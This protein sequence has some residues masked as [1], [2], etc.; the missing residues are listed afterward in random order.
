MP[1]ARNLLLRAAL[2][3]LPLI[4]ATTS[5]VAASN[6]G[7]EMPQAS[8]V[9]LSHKVRLLNYIVFDLSYYNWGLTYNSLKQSSAYDF[10]DWSTDNCSGPNV[11]MHAEFRVAC[12]RHDLS[13]RSLAAIDEASGRVWNERN[14]YVADE[15]FE[16]DIVAYCVQTYSFLLLY[17]K[18][19]NCEKD[20]RI[21]YLGVR[22][23]AGYRSNTPSGI[24]SDARFEV[25]T[26]S[27][28][29][30]YTTNSRNT[31]LPINYLTLDGKPFAPQRI[32]RFPAS[33]E[34]QLQVVRA[35]LQSV[36]GP[37]GPGKTWRNTGD[38]RLKAT[39]P[40]VISRSPNIVCSS[41][42][43]SVYANSQ[44]YR[45]PSS[46]TDHFIKLTN[47]Y[48][49]VCRETTS[50]ESD[51]K[52]L[53]IY[54]VEA[55]AFLRSDGTTDY[56][57]QDD[58]GL[59]GIGKVRD[60]EGIKILRLTASLKPNPNTFSFNN[61]DTF[62]AFT[63][64][65]GSNLDKVTIIANPGQTDSLLVKLDDI[66]YRTQTCR[67][68]PAMFESLSAVPRG[69]TIYLAMCGT[70]T[71]KVELQDPETGFVVTS[72]DR[73]T[74]P[75]CLESLDPFP[76]G[77][78]TSGTWTRQC[79][80]ERRNGRYARFYSF[81]LIQSA[82]V[83]ITL[84][85][86]ENTYLYL[87]RGS[88]KNSPVEASNDNGIT[89]TT[90]SRITRILPAGTYTAEATTFSNRRT[91]N[92]IIRFNTVA[93]TAP[94]PTNLRL[95][96]D[97][98]DDDELALNYTQSASPHYY[99]FELYRRN[100]ATGR[101]SLADTETD[102]SP[103]ETFQEVARG[104]WYQARGRNCLEAARANCGP[105]SVFSAPLEFSDP[106]VSIS[107]LA[108]SLESGEKDGFS[109]HSSDLTLDQFYTVTLTT[110]NSGI[111][112]N[113]ACNQAASANFTANTRSRNGGF[114]LYACAT[115]GGT[116]TAKL[117]K[118]GSSG[119]VVATATGAVKVAETPAASLS[120]APAD[121]EVG[122]SQT[123]TLKTNVA[124]VKIA[125]NYKGNTLTVNGT[126][127]GA[128]GDHQTRGNGRTITVKACAAGEGVIRLF[129]ASTGDWLKS[130]YFQVAET[131]A[132]SLSPEPAAIKVGQSQTLTLK[133]NVANVKI[134]VNYKGNVLTV[135]GT[136]PGGWG[137]H[138]T[139]GNGRTITIQACA[140]GEGAIRLFDVSTGDWLKSYYFQVAETPAASLSPAP[141][142]LEVGQSQ[143]LTLKTNVANV[144]IAV[145]YKGNVLTVDGTCPGGW[146]D[147]QTRGNGRTITIR[148]CAAGEGAIRLFDASSGDWLK[149]YY[150]Q[151]AG[152]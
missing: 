151:V 68:D 137:D 88:N 96:I 70:G 25:R 90:H 85:S 20:A 97:P 57:T 11:G 34:M 76:K 105:W 42:S 80:S 138:Q 37:P 36:K 150:F 4:V 44:S 131:P 149:S 26:T 145:N 99:Q 69:S 147:H 130:Y 91:G 127:P 21:Y 39:Y 120:P 87:L 22:K 104:Y 141:A 113:S 14:R 75:P 92:F 133:T 98:N 71:G 46:P 81:T 40:L 5:S 27:Q 135:D 60:Y 62:R 123:F 65:T 2:L 146:G 43:S 148:A 114:T 49:K 129:D 117:R 3:A 16:D 77:I 41:S 103:P 84:E 94:P 93:A 23:L 52:L 89:G 59:L 118:G 10:M 106:A 54:P 121:L 128:W 72:Y 55:L 12:L 33:Y 102:G 50:Q 111:G 38:L 32:S 108:S 73:L 144:K 28:N 64:T 136:C 109:V 95:S 29:C 142:D 116:V 18:R 110:S 132:A 78:N 115:P 35:N 30:S 6:P 13:W 125:V 9:E 47:F 51:D 56:G 63:L 143:T 74:G 66:K 101:Y 119:T 61:A 1:L 86:D 134:A 83:T 100:L 17:E 7:Q 152:G 140:A 124:N 107:G 48:L 45:Q 82:E 79:D 126:C 139:R 31:C 8:T 112:F 19:V 122:Q 24:D 53:E 67:R 15:K 58:G